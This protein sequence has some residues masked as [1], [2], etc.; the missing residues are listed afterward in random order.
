MG[1]ACQ[2]SMPI[3]YYPPGEPVSRIPVSPSTRSRT[4]YTYFSI[5]Y[6]GPSSESSSNCNRCRTFYACLCVWYDHQYS[7]LVE[8]G[9]SLS[10]RICRAPLTSF[11]GL[12]H[13]HDTHH[14]SGTQ[15]KLWWS[16]SSHVCPI[17]LP[18]VIYIDPL[19]C[20]CSFPFAG[21]SENPKRH[22][23]IGLGRVLPCSKCHPNWPCR[24]HVGS[25]G[26]G[27]VVPSAEQSDL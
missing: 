16:A 8:A 9:V 23:R 13:I 18:L 26:P 27:Y 2:F 5:Q 10:V 4:F 21:T 6:Q 19:R 12:H 7:H 20:A 15:Y 22:S 25:R 11:Q 17:I 3:S 1:G 14:L 24:D